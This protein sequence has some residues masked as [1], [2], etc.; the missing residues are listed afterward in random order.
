MLPQ[1]PLIRN[2]E[3]I[4]SSERTFGIVFT[5]VSALIGVWPIFSGVR[6][7]FWAFGL[8][9]TFFAAAML[10]PRLLAPLNAAWFHFGVLLH[11]V[12]NPVIMFVIYCGAVVP[13][14]LILKARGKD[15]L[16]LKL[17]RTATSYWIIREPPGPAA[18]SMR[19]QF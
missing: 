15:L 12:V 5:V 18:G 17:D 13:T 6:P 2:A 16:R 9:V 19:K 8:A 4:R 1:R 7:R 11:H 3:V 14:G 10:R